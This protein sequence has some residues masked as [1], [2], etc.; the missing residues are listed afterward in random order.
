[1]DEGK[2]YGKAKERFAARVL[3][4]ILRSLGGRARHRAAHPRRASRVHQEAGA[5]E[6]SS[7]GSRSGCGAWGGGSE[8]VISPLLCRH[9][10]TTWP[11]TPRGQH[12]KPAHVCC[13]TCGAELEYSWSEMRIVKPG[14]PRKERLVPERAEQ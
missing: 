2:R 7:E 4:R 1:M 5:Q 3:R 10:I 6:Q 8:C 11:Q 13:L 9:S 12:W 14:A